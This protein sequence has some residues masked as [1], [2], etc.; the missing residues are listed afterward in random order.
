[1][2]RKD[3]TSKRN[4]G[5]EELFIIFSGLAEKWLIRAVLGLLAL[6]IAAQFLLQFPA[7]RHYLVKV[8]QL[9][10]NSFDRTR[11]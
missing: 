3:D 4:N 6:L 8:E 2:K 1:M 5:Y 11:H 7:V 10:G 9:E